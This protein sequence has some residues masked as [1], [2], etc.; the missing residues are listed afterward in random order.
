MVEGMKYNW[1]F[2]KVYTDEG[3]TGIGEGTKWPGSPMILEACRH[4]GEVLVG[5]DSSRIDYLW[6]KLYRDFNWMGQ[7]GPV[8][9]AISAI[10]I[11]LWDLAGKRAGMPVYQL[12]GGQYRK[13]IKLYAKYWFLNGRASRRSTRNRHEVSRNAAFC[14][15]NGPLC[16][17]E[18][19][20]W[21]GFGR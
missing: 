10:D 15:Q 3:L 13:Q 21:S 4:V 12:L 17:C 6:T 11:A 1:V 9:S 8:L 7:G 16:T 5:E 19:L 2:V 14:L 18:L 20:V